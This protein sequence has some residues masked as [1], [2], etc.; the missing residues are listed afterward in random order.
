MKFLLQSNIWDE[1]GYTR[2]IDSVANAG[3]DYEIVN[4]IP[5]THDL[6]NAEGEIK[7][8]DEDVTHIF[9]SGRFVNI[10]R[11]LGYPTYESFEKVRFDLF[12]GKFW[13][14]GKAATYKLKNLRKEEADMFPCFIKP[15][16]EKFFTGLVIESKEDLDKIQ[17]A[18]SFIEDPEDEIIY[19]SRPQTIQQ[20]IR[21][22]IIDNKIISASAYKNG[23]QRKQFRIDATHDAWEACQSM[24]HFPHP[25]R[26]Y[27]AAPI[28]YRLPYVMDL[29]LVNNEWKIV[30][31]NNINSSGLYECDTDAIVNA[32]KHF[33][34]HV[35]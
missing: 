33:N 4:V 2:F 7:D 21:F 27:C 35:S 24:L 16:T 28:P 12:T 1:Y 5:F 34:H 8:F 10:C 6:R 17:Y 9:G 26:M 11:S 29:G 25:E 20:E 32:F 14:N 13:I 15:H 18:T 23:S 30:E 31:L 3:I 19:V 22:Y